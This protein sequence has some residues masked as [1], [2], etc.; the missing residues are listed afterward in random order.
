MDYEVSIDHDNK[1]VCALCKGTIDVTDAMSVTKDVRARAFELG[2]SVLY[3]AT[4]TF[5]QISFAQAYTY[6][7]DIKNLYADPKHRYG[8][9]AIVCAPGKDETFWK[10]LE[11]TA[12]N[13]GIIVRVFLD[14][15]E[16]AQWLADDAAH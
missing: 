9:A 7:R 13:A 1:I 10:F 5:P 15:S 3:D 16:A 6:P 2:Y 4:E 8:K 11:T 14:K 12:R